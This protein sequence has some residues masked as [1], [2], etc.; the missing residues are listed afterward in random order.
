MENIELS[1]EI[2]VPSVPISSLLPDILSN[3]PIIN[4][5]YLQSNMGMVSIIILLLLLLGLLFYAYKM[6]KLPD[7]NSLKKQVSNLMQKKT[8]SFDTEDEYESE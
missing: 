7:F 8:V 1:K 6:D 3:I 4:M 2:P 5:D